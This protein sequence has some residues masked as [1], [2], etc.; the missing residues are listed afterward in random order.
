LRECPLDNIEICGICEES[1][2]T[3]NFPSLPGIKV[4]Y[5]GEKEAS[6]SLYAMAPQKPWK[7]MPSGM[8]QNSASQFPYSHNQMWNTPMPWKPW[9]PQ[10]IP[11]QIWQQGWCGPSY[12]GMTTFPYPTLPPYTT[13]PPQAPQQQINQPQQ[14]QLPSP[15][16]PPRPTQIPAQPIL[17][18]KN[19]KPVQAIYGTDLQT[20]PTYSIMLVP[21]Q[22]IHLRSGK[23]L[24]PKS[25]VIVQ[26]NEEEEAPIQSEIDKF[27]SPSQSH[28]QSQSQSQV[29]T[30]P[31]PVLRRNNYYSPNQPPFPERL[32]L[33][34]PIIPSEFDL[35]SELKKYLY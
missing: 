2:S 21:L 11:Q 8:V 5:R 22:E 27:Q 35:V 20:F 19:N 7:P 13:Y 12:D 9:P 16:N 34:K 14:L 33:E 17:N 15:Q 6:S 24:N 32:A 10:P 26:E 4:V 28:I 1:H 23:V 30:T 31:Q 18:P 3:S 25:S 29:Q